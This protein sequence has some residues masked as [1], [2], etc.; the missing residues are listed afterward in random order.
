MNIL[1]SIKG[2][3]LDAGIG[4]LE[5]LYPPLKPLVERWKQDVA[6]GKLT[7]E[8]FEATFDTAAD[9]IEGFTGPDVDAFIE[10]C[11]VVVHEAIKA[12][13]LAVIAFAP[14]P[15]AA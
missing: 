5:M 7:E 6:D 9:F 8:N 10:Q 3:G 11:K 1:D 13:K 12:E 14:K 4:F 2:S 15:A